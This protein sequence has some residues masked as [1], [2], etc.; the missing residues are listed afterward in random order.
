VTK[1]IRFF[2]FL[3]GAILL[4]SSQSTYAATMSNIDV[5]DAS[6]GTVVNT[7]PNN[8]TI[9]TALRNTISQIK[10]LAP[11]ASIQFDNKEIVYR[12]PIQP[13]IVLQTHNLIEAYVVKMSSN[14]TVLVCFDNHDRSRIYRFGYTIPLLSILEAA[15]NQTRK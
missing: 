11:Q 5:F 4:F 3:V 8:E 7:L 12:V 10:K 1:R 6:K 14:E 2:G 13:P 9:Q 15:N